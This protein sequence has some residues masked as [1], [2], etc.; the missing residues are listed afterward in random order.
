MEKISQCLVRTKP[1]KA[2]EKYGNGGGRVCATSAVLRYWAASRRPVVPPHSPSPTRVF[3]L[4]NWEII[5]TKVNVADDDVI[6]SL[7]PR[8]EPGAGAL[9]LIR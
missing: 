2:I 8:S 1:Q 6:V 3:A 5:K 9:A 7:F 4:S